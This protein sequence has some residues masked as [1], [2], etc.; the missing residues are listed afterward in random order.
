MSIPV[1][2]LPRALPSAQLGSKKRTGTPS[3]LRALRDGS[4]EKQSREK[5]RE[6]AP[7]GA[8][9]RPGAHRLLGEGKGVRL[10]ETAARPAGDKPKSGRWNKEGQGKGARP[11][12]KRG[13]GTGEW[14]HPGGRGGKSERRGRA[15]PGLPAGCLSPGGAPRV[16]VGRDGKVN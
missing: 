3:F 2:D 7:K 4:E 1:P 11:G 15:R 13:D 10:H 14:G 9:G 6:R 16:R 5:Q 8:A 12:W